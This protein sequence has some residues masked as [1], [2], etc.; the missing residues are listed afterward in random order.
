M[1]PYM[2][3][4]LSTFLIL[5]TTSAQAASSIPSPLPIE[6]TSDIG[7]RLL[8]TNDDVLPGETS[9]RTY[10][11]TMVGDETAGSAKYLSLD[12]VHSELLIP[13]SALTIDV[14]GEPLKSVA[15]TKKTSQGNVKVPLQNQHLTKGTHEVTVRFTGIIEGRMCDTGN[16]SGSWL[17]VRPSS[18]VSVGN[19]AELSLNDY[20]NPFT[21]TTNQKLTVVLPSS[22]KIDSLEAG[23]L[24]YRQLKGDATDP[25]YVTLQYEEQVKS[26]DGRYVFVGQTDSFNGP[27]KD[28]IQELKTLPK[29]E[30]VLFEQARLVSDGKSADAMFVLA[31]NADAFEGT[32]DHL[33][34]VQQRQ[35]LNGEQLILTSAPSIQKSGD[36]INLRTLGASDLMLSGSQA[37]SPNY[38]Y[39]LPVIDKQSV[40]ELDVRFKASENLVAEREGALSPE[41]IAWV[42]GIP[43]SIPLTDMETDDEWRH[44]VIR[45][46]AS[47][48]KKATFLDVSFEAN[49]LRSEAP[50]NAS[51]LDRWIFVSSDSQVKLPVNSGQAN[52]E[53]FLN[54]A[55]LFTMDSGI[56][57]VVPDEAN[58]KSLQNMADVMSGLPITP[59]TEQVEFVRS[60]EVTEEMVSNRSIFFIGNPE[61]SPLFNEQKEN[62]IVTKD[63]QIDLAQ[64]GFIPET[65]SEFAWIQPSPWNEDKAMIVVSTK[66]AID[67][68]LIQTLSFP[69]E[70]FSVAVKNQNGSIFTNSSSVASENSNANATS[71]EQSSI[72]V[73]SKWYFVG[74]IVLIGLIIIILLYMRRNKKIT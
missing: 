69:S 10:T 72:S 55:S 28:F 48:L 74:F 50:C 2:P 58:E 71:D 64:Y 11:Y 15:L 38:F 30:E 19:K 35:Q 3:Y 51:D 14:D 63:E 31:E 13:P 20:P 57:F 22:P 62:W 47:T 53:V 44:H 1:K 7:G 60:S 25:D 49:G 23:L 43:H 21:Q 17:T 16:T 67:P 46:D 65:S 70:T 8:T 45:V 52:N 12:W 24:L 18:F 26:L 40:V 32:L 66:D 39:P 27:V 9:S 56:L 73:D 34:L 41:L 54:M 42:N 4:L 59:L 36:T 29:N 6:S 33:L 61:E 5:S 68:N 37:V